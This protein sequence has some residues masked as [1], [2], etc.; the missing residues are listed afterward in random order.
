MQLKLTTFEK[1][2]L[3]MFGVLGAAVFAVLIILP[4]LPANR[5]TSEPLADPATLTKLIANAPIPTPIQETIAVFH[6]IIHAPALA[7]ITNLQECS[8]PTPTARNGSKVD[9]PPAFTCL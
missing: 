5:H 2:W 1:S 4:I 8:E 9:S 7:S 6:G 3:R